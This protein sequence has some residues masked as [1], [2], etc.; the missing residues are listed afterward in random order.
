MSASNPDYAAAVTAFYL[1]LRQMHAG[2]PVHEP[3]MEFGAPN[4]WWG[5]RRLRPRPHEGLDLVGFRANASEAS[6]LG[7]S[8]RPIEGGECVAV[9]Q[10]FLCYTAIVRRQAPSELLWCYAHLQL[11]PGV[12]PGMMLST[13]DV[14]G[15]VP[16]DSDAERRSKCPP[17][18]HLSLLHQQSGGLEWGSVDWRTIHDMP[19]LSFVPLALLQ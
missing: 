17:H 9:F 16:A 12:R 1:W 6:I 13:D 11:N 18:L 2:E 19:Q 7:M 3:G 4:A 8:L 14:L 5:Q 10:D 15:W